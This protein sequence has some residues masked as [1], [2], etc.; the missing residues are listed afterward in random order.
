MRLS[1]LTKQAYITR[2]RLNR[3]I[4]VQGNP[5]GYKALRGTAADY[6]R[7]RRAFGPEEVERAVEDA[8]C[9]EV[10]EKALERFWPFL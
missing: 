3:N 4:V 2:R 1:G 6:E 8:K 10:A 5:R 7:V 9:R